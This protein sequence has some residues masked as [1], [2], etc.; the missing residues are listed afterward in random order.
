MPHLASARAIISHRRHSA[1]SRVAL[2]AS[3]VLGIALGSGAASAQTPPPQQFSKAELQFLANYH[4]KAVCSGVFV[5]GRTFEAVRGEDKMMSSAIGANVDST[6]KTVTTTIAGGTNGFAAYRPGYGC[7]IAAGVEAADLAARDLPSAPTIRKSANRRAWPAGDAPASQAALR[8]GPF[9]GVQAAAEAAFNERPGQP[10][11][12]VRAIVVVHG[13]RIVAEHYAPGFGLD[14]QL[15]SYSVAKSITAVLAGILVDRRA[16][17]LAGPTGLPAWSAPQDPR[18]AIKLDDLLHMSSG[19]AFQQDPRGLTDL[20]VMT[21]STRDTPAFAA[22]KPLEVQPGSRWKYSDGDVQIINGL[23]R[24]AFGEDERAYHEFP[25]KSLFGPLGMD[26]TEID[27]DPAGTFIGSVGV[28]ATARDY[29]RFGQLLLQRGRWNGRQ[30]V[31]KTW[32]DYIR[33]PAPSSLDAKYGALF[34]LNGHG[35]DGK[36]AWPRLPKD[37]FAALGYEG[38]SVVVFPSHDLVVVTLAKSDRRTT[39][40]PLDRTADIFEAYQKAQG[41]AKH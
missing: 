7:T 37:T 6:A 34:W 9:A 11:E 30:V 33:T 36:D 12:N 14:T 17:Q 31:S 21:S 13:G 1:V 4:A 18:Q 5:S 38:Q 27:L 3:G 15:Q 20:N 22:S 40:N 41:L 24:R 35:V 32:I 8:S 23:F 10:R 25:R 16:L 39:Q 2:I 19:L 26:H 28:F 29:A